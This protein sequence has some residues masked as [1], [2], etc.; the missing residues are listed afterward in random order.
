MKNNY[1]N[2]FIKELDKF[3]YKYSSY[4]LFADFCECARCA[5]NSP[6]ENNESN[7]SR[8]N[9]TVRKYEK[10]DN[11][12]EYFGNLFGLLVLCLNDK[13]FTDVL[14]SIYMQLEIA[15]KKHLGQC[16]T[17]GSI[18]DLCG[19]LTLDSKMV[20]EIEESYFVTLNDCCVG[21]GSMVLSFAG[22][23]RE[24]GYNPQKQ[25][26]VICNDVDTLCVNM[27]YIQ[28]SL[29]GIPAIVLRGDTLTQ[30]FSEKYY[31]PMWFMSGYYFKYERWFAEY[32][33]VGV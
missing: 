7:E 19:N 24:K 13:P 1:E 32:T 28:L 17:P 16:F 18:S 15:D 5:I 20:K 10:S 21:G 31:T 25:L 9:E 22:A 23:M 6:L 26:C 14:G 27:A 3:R 11:I 29:N 33:E 30:K 4:Q 8:Y 2:Q 12:V